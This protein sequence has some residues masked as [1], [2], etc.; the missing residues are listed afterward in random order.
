MEQHL[1][2]TAGD[3][4]E[5]ERE[6]SQRNSPAATPPREDS[7]DGSPKQ[8]TPSLR[9]TFQDDVERLREEN[10]AIMKVRTHT[11]SHTD[12]VMMPVLFTRNNL[13]A[14]ICRLVFP[15]QVPACSARMPSVQDHQQT[16]AFLPSFSRIQLLLLFACCFCTVSLSVHSNCRTLHC[17]GCRSWFHVKWSWQN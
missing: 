16:T 6:L 14:K 4:E 11:E 13:L 15:L 5:A 9:Q 2:E 1:Q 8:Q 12:V 7:E 3:L 17:S 10:G